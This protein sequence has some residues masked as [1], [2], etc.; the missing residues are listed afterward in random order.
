MLSPELRPMKRRLNI[1]VIMADQMTPGALPIHGGPAKTP[2][3]N[4]FAERGVVFDAAYCNSPLCAPSRVAFMSGRLAS[5]T[6]AYDNAAE[7]RSEIPTIAHYLRLAGYRTVLAGKM[8]FCGADQLHGFEQRLTT[9]IYPADFGWTPD[10][11]KPHARPSWYHNMGSVLEAGPCVR[12]NQIDFDEEVAFSAERAIYDHARGS[13]ERPLCLMVSFTHP[14]DPFTVPER[15]WKLYAHDEIPLP[16]VPL[17]PGSLDPHEKRL[18]HICDM[19]GAKLTQDDV[20][21]ARRAYYGAISYV[22]DHLGRLLSVLEAT[23]LARDTVIVVTSDHGE[24]LGERGF[25][26]KMSFFEGACRVPLIVHAPGRF[27]ARRISEA[28]SL[29]D[30]LPT[31]VEIGLDGAGDARLEEIDGRSLIPHLRGAGG[32]DEALGEYLAEGAIAPIVMIRR[33]RHKFVLSP[34]DPDQ[35]YDLDTDPDERSNLAKA[36]EHEKLCARFRAEVARRWDLASLD[37]AVRESQRRRHI[38]A[39]ALSLG[40]L[41]PWDY[42]PP[43]D[44]SREYIRNHMS[45]DDLEARARFP[46]VRRTSE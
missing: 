32:H 17:A 25:W 23:G 40:R 1:L 29:V 26:Y 30:I 19:D 6:G 20:R 44:A 11:D 41:N 27:A 38:V 31:L 35:L 42:Q 3:M 34:P 21:R 9:D 15:W 10:W 37:R 45:L 12:S 7:F 8:H 43:R 2:Y 24:M 14:H 39:S 18:W 22:D 16:R 46:A 5:R 28:V 4:T 36:P 13:D 33:G